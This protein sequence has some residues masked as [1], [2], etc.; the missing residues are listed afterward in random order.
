MLYTCDVLTI[1]NPL[2]AECIPDS[3]GGQSIE[4]EHWTPLLQLLYK[5]PEQY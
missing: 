2:A 4:V 3:D 5:I 1:V